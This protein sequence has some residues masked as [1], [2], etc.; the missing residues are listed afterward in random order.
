MVGGFAGNQIRKG[1]PYDTAATVAGAI[2]GGVGAR[3]AAEHWDKARHKKKEQR[4]E[5][6]KGEYGNG[7]GRRSERWH[8]GGRRDDGSRR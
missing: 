8:D 7:E 2:L 3:E 6:W 4:D 5:R 1:R